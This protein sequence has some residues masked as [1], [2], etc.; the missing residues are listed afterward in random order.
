MLR[1]SRIIAVLV[2][3]VMI[4][5][6]IEPACAGWFWDDEPGQESYIWP[7]LSNDTFDTLL[8]AGVGFLSGILFSPVLTPIPTFMGAGAIIGGL[9][10]LRFLVRGSDVLENSGT[11]EN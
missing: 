1:K 9:I 6:V 10:A 11:A 2:V 5:T 8:F 7:I 3:C 4:F